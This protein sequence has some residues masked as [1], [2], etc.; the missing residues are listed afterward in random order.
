MNRSF[1]GKGKGKGYLYPENQEQV[2]TWKMLVGF[3]L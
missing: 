3:C 2:F 1:Q